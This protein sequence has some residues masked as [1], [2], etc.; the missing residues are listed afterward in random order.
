[1][2]TSTK[3]FRSISVCSSTILVV[4]LS[5]VG[6]PDRALAQIGAVATVSDLAYS[7][8]TDRTE[9]KRLRFFV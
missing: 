7:E 4:C 9:A 6:D 8:L 5:V 2:N 3:L 1:M